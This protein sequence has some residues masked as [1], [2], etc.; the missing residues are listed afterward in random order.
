MTE[1]GQNDP[2]GNGLLVYKLIVRSLEGHSDPLRSLLPTFIFLYVIARIFALSVPLF[3]LFYFI[4]ILIVI[5]LYINKKL[6]FVSFKF[7]FFNF[8]N[9][10]I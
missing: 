7:L 6:T 3:L 9:Y 2:Q 4:S 5:I 1:E 8:F 10:I